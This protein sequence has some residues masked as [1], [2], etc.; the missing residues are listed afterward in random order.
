MNVIILSKGFAS[1]AN[2]RGLGISLPYLFIGI[3]CQVLYKMRLVSY[4]TR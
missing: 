2:I 3:K 4:F 1:Y